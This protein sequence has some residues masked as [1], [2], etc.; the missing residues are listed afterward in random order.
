M[1]WWILLAV[2][3]LIIIAVLV[4]RVD[5]RVKYIREAENDEVFANVALLFGL[6]KLRYRVPAV[7]L[8]GL[9]AGIALRVH[10]PHA[11]GTSPTDQMITRE[12]V[13]RLVRRFRDIVRS[14]SNY[15]EWV[16]DTLSHFHVVKVRWKTR[17][18]LG[19]APET[20]VTAGIVWSMKSTLLAQLL[21]LFKL[22]TRPELAVDPDFNEIGFRTEA[23]L[24]LHVRVFRLLQ[25]AAMLIVRI[26]RN[27]GGW[28]EWRQIVFRKPFKSKPSP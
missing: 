4:S 11:P 10:K 14:V 16:T 25:A 22:E 24:H 27:G 21:R 26:F 13:A 12:D 20:A 5:I 17:F 8:K 7:R 19:E 9:F 3:M 2:F 6:V 28:K 18:G 1:F 23:E 15:T